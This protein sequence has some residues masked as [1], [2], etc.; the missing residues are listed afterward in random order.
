[1]NE[2]VKMTKRD[3][4][5]VDIFSEISQRKISK[6]KEAEVLGMS[7]RHIQ[8]LYADFREFGI[9]PPRSQYRRISSR[10]AADAA[11]N[12]ADRIFVR[13][14]SLTASRSWKSF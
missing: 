3:I 11:L 12:W 10:F 7:I 4:S 14:I 13:P 2:G 9:S 6:T 8:R 1:M 5:K